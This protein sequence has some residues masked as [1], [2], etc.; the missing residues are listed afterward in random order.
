M[1]FLFTLAFSLIIPLFL[2]AQ[3]FPSGN[4]LYYKLSP[5]EALAIAESDSAHLVLNQYYFQKDSAFNLANR[6]RYGNFLFATN[7]E[8]YVHINWYESCSITTQFL[9]HDRDFALVVLDS[10]GKSL[11]DAKVRLG[12]K[13]IQFD[14]K[15]A[16]YRLKNYKAKQDTQR[17][18]IQY[19]DEV[20]A[21]NI[22][23]YSFSRRSKR[24]PWQWIKHQFWKT[25]YWFQKGGF[26]KKPKVFKGY[27]AFSKPKYRP[28]D[29]LKVKG[30]FTNRRGKPLKQALELQIGSYNSAIWKDTIG[31][32]SPGNYSTEIVLADSLNLKLDKRYQVKFIERRK[33]GQSSIVFRHNFQYEDYELDEVVYTL[34]T[35][36]EQY[37]LGEKV[38]IKTSAKYKNG[39]SVPDASIDLVIRSKATELASIKPIWQK[40]MLIIPDTLWTFQSEF[41]THGELEISLPDSIFPKAHLKLWIDALF[42]NSNGEL[43]KESKLISFQPRKVKVKKPNLL[44][45]EQDELVIKCPI[46]K[47]CPQ[48]KLFLI[49]EGGDFENQKTITFPHRE[50]I[51]SQVE[52]YDL[53][54][55][56]CEGF[57]TSLDLE[58]FPSNVN[59]QAF[60]KSNSLEFKMDNP[61]GISIYFEIYEGKRLIKRKIID[62]VKY[63]ETF[64]AK[65]SKT[66]HIHIQYT[67]AGMLKSKKIPL[68]FYKKKLNIQ[69]DQPSSISPG[70]SVQLKIQ[71]KDYK[72][73]PIP[74]VDLT[75]GAINGQFKKANHFTSPQISYKPGK[76]PRRKQQFNSYVGGGIHARF[77]MN[78]TWA[79][80]TS[81]DTTLFYRL[82]IPPN[83]VL[84]HYDTIVGDTFYQNIAQFSPYIIN[85]GQIEPVILIYCNKKLVYYYDT[86]NQQPYSFIGKEGNNT[87]TIRTRNKIYNIKNVHLKKGY[88]LE[89]ALDVKRQKSDTNL[90]DIR[91]NTMP[92][93]LTRREQALI[94]RK[95]FLFQPARSG[96]YQFY[97][98]DKQVQIIK[99]TA[100]PY[101]Y[102][103]KKEKVAI[104][105]GPFHNAPITFTFKDQ[106][107]NTFRFEPGFSY[108]I[109]SDRE[110]LYKYAWKE[111]SHKFPV[112]IPS[113]K[114]GQV[115]FSPNQIE[116]TSAVLGRLTYHYT[117][118]KTAKGNGNLNIS[119]PSP[120]PNLAAIILKEP[121]DSLKIFKGNQLYIRNLIPGSYT[122]MLVAWDSSLLEKKL[123][124]Y[125]NAATYIF[126]KGN[127]F[128][129]DFQNKIF[130]R[131]LDRHIIKTTLEK[132]GAKDLSLKTEDY[133][134]PNTIRGQVLD[135]TGE[136]LIGAT[137]LV[138]GTN[139]GT[140]TDVEGNYLLTLPEGKTE[141]IIN[142]VGFAS[143]TVQLYGNNNVPLT[144]LEESRHLLN[145]VV[146]TGYGEKKARYLSASVAGVSS[147][148]Q[149]KEQ[150]IPINNL[151]AADNNS[152]YLA[153]NL[154]QFSG[155]QLRNN[156]R[157]EAFWIPNLITDHNGEAY[158]NVTFPDNLTQWKTFV[159]GMN[160]KKQAGIGLSQTNAIKK[161][162]G[163]LSVPRF[164]V[165]EDQVDIIGKSVNYTD[166]TLP[167]S[168][169]FQLGEKIIQSQ[170]L[171]LKDAHI[172]KASI[173]TQRGQD[174]IQVTYQLTMNQYGDGEQ[175]PIPVY[176]KGIKETE[177][178]FLL[179]EK[180]TIFSLT[181]DPNKGPIQ[182]HAETHALPY[183]YQS[184]DYLIQYPHG[185]NEQTA[186]RLM[187]TLLAKQ[188]KE[189]KQLPF[190]QEHYIR[191]GLKRLEKSQNKNGSWGWWKNNEGSIWM[192]TYIL[193]VLQMAK[194]QGYSS[195]A[196]KKGLKYLDLQL[197][198][199][200]GQNLLSV[201]SLL[202]NTKRLIDYSHYLDKFYQSV[203]RPNLNE[204]FTIIKIKQAQGLPYQIEEV[205]AH[206]NETVYGDYYFGKNSYHWYNNSTQISLLAY[207]ILEQAGKKKICRGIE[208]YFLR[209]RGILSWRNTFETAQI[210]ATILDRYFDEEGKGVHLA[211]LEIVG[212]NKD[213]FSHFPLDLTYSPSR[214]V[215]I[216]KTGN[217]PV[218]LAVYQN[219]WNTD[220]KAKKEHFEIQTK[221]FQNDQAVT[222]LKSKQPA[223]LK[224]KV[225]VK[226]V[227]EY[228]MIEIPIPAGCSYGGKQQNYYYGYYKAGKYHRNY[229]VHREYYRDR[230]AIFCRQLPKGTYEYEI[231]L[232]PRYNGQFTLNPCRAEEMYFPVFNGNN[233]IKST[234]IKD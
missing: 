2:Y 17:L 116:K 142:Y 145:E 103:R 3:S 209:K 178:Y 175:K 218:Y 24:T 27:M 210:L 208:R 147:V 207:Q 8:E 153:Q 169:S 80:R 70:E 96:T 84:M 160:D 29:T 107:I 58:E 83:G 125:P 85:N 134:G 64:P 100:L 190:E 23:A 93:T 232:E 172:E 102:Y 51:N 16:S 176:K 82:R 4:T 97:Q 229:E 86:D 158:V 128:Q 91:V 104:K 135:E 214:E 149:S 75:T 12:N 6:P 167:I 76:F 193:N 52:Y 9:D 216:K 119:F 48:G 13:P 62:Q 185:C 221:L 105:L 5:E 122:L 171:Q 47:P 140:V 151:Q 187:A 108:S 114:L 110:R 66:Y 215:T 67:W 94:K 211:G 56:S 182:I 120:K 10:M 227:A 225:E 121:N 46:D 92:D 34:E 33:N 55:V 199:L 138:K 183:L 226:K 15:S 165:E 173:Q 43:Q 180:D 148:D 25:K 44:R 30:Y 69:V 228:V 14:Q 73:R 168:T 157:D 163:Q 79:K 53:S 162:V 77:P 206:L 60:R 50:K 222:H 115:V 124:I 181:F 41:N 152:E 113:P 234:G 98:K 37:Q 1:Q 195:N 219:Y 204:Q 81:V 112:K 59:I 40:D 101:R 191:K 31:P 95:I 203:S 36:K 174:S 133:Y 129:K 141:L 126:L 159:I 131:C 35:D 194:T 200:E 154:E 90:L 65:N 26:W 123:T 186:S 155:F 170:D 71:V 89:F 161:L 179:L 106:F 88:K 144:F 99:Y 224:A 22:A 132:E 117:K 213:T 111:L 212:L 20:L 42:S 196:I 198:Q 223:M 217:D 188:L 21:Y 74:N 39:L 137:I 197:D 156:F 233:E 146:V 78:E 127:S 166:Q 54:C 32:L 63:K 202:S 139:V 189:R 136:P 19:R 177:G 192:T 143:K 18:V 61:R 184:I 49:S 11:S 38:T 118:E 7:V 87:V 205:L 45:I 220:P 201:L 72:D 57:E 28:G 130:Q 231:E 150:N 109:S 230:V 68:P 164:L